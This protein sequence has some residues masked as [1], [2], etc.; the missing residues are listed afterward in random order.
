MPGEKVLDRR[1]AA[2]SGR[3]WGQETRSSACPKLRMYHFS[4]RPVR[5][6]VRA[7]SLFPLG[8]YQD[9]ESTGQVV[10]QRIAAPVSISNISDS[11]WVTGWTAKRFIVRL[12]IRT[13]ILKRICRI[14]LGTSVC[15]HAKSS[16]SLDGF[17][18]KLIF[19]DFFFFENLA[20]KFSF[21][22]I[23][24]GIM[25]TLNEHPCELM[26]SR[27]VFFFFRM[28]NTSDKSYR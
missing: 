17:L 23:L 8:L 25:G 13:S 27:C 15:P 16:L 20:R 10:E 9:S 6:N 26:T 3:C 24:I 22:D 19:E 2:V 18:W 28:R 14:A 1:S 11:D 12:R 5:I 4:G 7:L 21:V